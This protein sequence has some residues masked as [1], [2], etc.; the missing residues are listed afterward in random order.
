[1]VRAILTDLGN[2]VCYFYREWVV[3]GYR[4]ALRRTDGKVIREAV[5]GAAGKELLFE[6]E[7]GLVSD[8][9]YAKKFLKLLGGGRIERDKFWRIHTNM[10]EPNW[11]VIELWQSLQRR[12]GV[13]LVAVSDIDPYRLE[14]MLR[15]STL[16]FDGV[17]ASF[18]VGEKKPHA[19]MYRKALELAQ[20][21]PKECVFVDDRE[22]NVQAARKMGIFG[23]HFHDAPQLV[24]ELRQ[25]GLEV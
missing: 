22:E 25:T 1:M 23:I 13:R 9:E 14:Y 11:P 16:N 10:F 19:A 17:A 21:A 5:M 6:Y 18:E 12:K 2:V 8:E 24:A 7:R 4:S 20:S 3:E 15:M